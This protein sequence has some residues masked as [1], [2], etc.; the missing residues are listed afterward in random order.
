MGERGVD[1]GGPRRDLIC[2]LCGAVKS[3][4]D[5]TL[6]AFANQRAYCIPGDDATSNDGLHLRLS[7][8]GAIAGNLFIDNLFSFQV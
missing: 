6:T 5:I 1:L 7:A 8:F 4:L 2:T 3:S